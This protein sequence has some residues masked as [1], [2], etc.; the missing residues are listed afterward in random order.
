MSHGAVTDR[1]HRNKLNGIEEYSVLLVTTVP[2]RLTPEVSVRGAISYLQPRSRIPRVK[3]R[4]WILNAM[5]KRI[6]T[7]DRT[8]AQLPITMVVTVTI[9]IFASPCNRGGIPETAIGHR[10]RFRVDTIEP[11]SINFVMPPRLL[12]RVIDETLS[13]GIMRGCVNITKY[14]DL[15]GVRLGKN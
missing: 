14:D 5:R 6:S 7:A 11:R 4:G 1:D 10:L 9:I 15:R 8:F 2:K 12:S 13:R 3:T